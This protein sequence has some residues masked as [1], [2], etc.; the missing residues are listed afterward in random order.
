MTEGEGRHVEDVV[1]VEPTDHHHVEFDGQETSGFG[2]RDAI[3]YIAEFGTARH[4]TKAFGVE[5]INAN[6]DAVEPGLLEIMGDGCQLDGIGSHGDMLDTGDGF[7]V[8]HQRDQVAPER[9]FATG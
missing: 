9:W 6:V 8:A 1:V 7:D 5:G 3:P 2:C 4:D